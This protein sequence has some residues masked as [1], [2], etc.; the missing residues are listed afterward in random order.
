MKNSK[1]V[2]TLFYSEPLSPPDL[3]VYSPANWVPADQAPFDPALAA[4]AAA[5]GKKMAALSVSTFPG[6]AGQ[7]G[8]PLQ[9]V[10]TPQQTTPQVYYHYHPQ[11]PQQSAQYPGQR[12]SHYNGGYQYGAGAGG[13]NVSWGVNGGGGGG[14]ASATAGNTSS[15][16]AEISPQ[17]RHHRNGA[18]GPGTNGYHYNTSRLESCT[19]V[20]TTRYQIEINIF[21]C[22][23]KKA[24]T[25]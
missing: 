6:Q 4:A 13:G 10:P 24:S 14:S 7:G 12:G 20:Y 9:P 23:H 21:F 8:V 11:Q 2:S 3:S 5:N 25:Y 19:I 17:G 15:S 18:G 16:S 22:L 1:H